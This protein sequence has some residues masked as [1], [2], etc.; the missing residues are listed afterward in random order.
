M[1]NICVMSVNTPVYCSQKAF[2]VKELPGDCIQTPCNIQTEDIIGH[3]GKTGLYRKK[4]RTEASSG[5]PLHDRSSLQTE[6]GHVSNFPI[7]IYFKV[8]IPELCQKYKLHLDNMFLHLFTELRF[9]ARGRK[10]GKKMDLGDQLWEFPWPS[11]AS[12]SMVMFTS[13]KYRVTG[14]RRAGGSRKSSL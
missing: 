6:G 11:G 8:N 7:S 3:G 14:I 12:A 9:F 2:S 13:L 4:K 5:F 10:H 1:C